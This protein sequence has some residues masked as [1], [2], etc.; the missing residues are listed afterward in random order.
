[1]G[2]VCQ[3]QVFFSLC[4]HFKC[5]VINFHCEVFFPPNPRHSQLL[6]T[7][8]FYIPPR[9]KNSCHVLFSG[10]TSY[11]TYPYLSDTKMWENCAFWNH[12]CVLRC[13]H[14][15]AGGFFQ[16]LLGKTID[17]IRDFPSLSQEPGQISTQQV[18][19]AQKP[20]HK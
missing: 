3:H 12:I 14:H 9:K 1:M 2:R 8:L 5:F 6:Y 10:V 15:G 13:W 18:S 7:S 17:L 4:I 11:R 19:R 16:V 20:M